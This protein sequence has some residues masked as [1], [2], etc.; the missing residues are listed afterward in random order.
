MMKRS[1][2]R[3]GA[4]KWLWTGG[5]TSVLLS[6]AALGGSWGV[7]YG[8][9]APAATSPTTSSPTGS[10]G[11]VVVATSTTSSTSGS[12]SVVG[13]AAPGT[14]VS[15]IPAN[16]NIPTTFAPTGTTPVAPPIDASVFTTTTPAPITATVSASHGGVI[17]AGNAAVIVPPAALA[18]IPGQQAT[19][20]VKPATNVPVPGGPAQFSP[21]GT[22]LSVSISDANGNPVTTFPVPIPIE[23]KYNAADLGQANGNASSLTAA[24][25]VD[26]LTPP[27]ANPLGFPTGTFVIFPSEHTSLDATAGT[28][29]I[30]TQ[31]IGSTISVVTNPVGY[32]QTLTSTSELSS[33]DATTA[34]VFGTK[35]ASSYLQVAEP[36]IGSSLLV[37]DPDTGNYSYVPAT[38]VGPS[39]PPPAKTAAG[40][41]RGTRTAP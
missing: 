37:L 33:F 25:I 28:L 18:G 31:A 2:V 23:V 20:D 7:A 9:T 38:D 41:V 14:G 19:F 13:S 4:V 26:A 15:D 11:G 35:P 24:Y 30:T 5:I 3:R 32:V 8:Q 16:L 21:N 1:G 17:I 36:Q 27:I 12:V 10:T 22:Q 29:T 6:A 40:V 34:Q 39:G